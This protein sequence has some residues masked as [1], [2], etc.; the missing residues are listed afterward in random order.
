MPSASVK[1]K[2]SRRT[3]LLKLFSRAERPLRFADLLGAYARRFP[4]DAGGHEALSSALGALLHSGEVTRVGR[5]RGIVRYRLDGHSSRSSGTRRPDPAIVWDIVDQAYRATGGPV[6]TAAIRRELKARGAWPDRFPRLVAVLDTM[7]VDPDARIM[8]TGAARSAAALRRAPAA[9]SRARVPG[10]WVPAWAA[11]Q[12]AV[13]APSAA[14]ALRYAIGAASREAG[15]PVSQRELRWWIAAQPTDS[16]WRRELSPARTGAALRNVALRD[17]GRDDEPHALRVVEGPLTCH[18]GA[19]KRYTFGPTTDAE[20][21]ACHFMDAIIMLELDVELQTRIALPQLGLPAGVRRRLECARAAAVHTALATYCAS[22][23]T[24][25]FESA[26]RRRTRA[27]RAIASWQEAAIPAG[28]A[29]ITLRTEQRQERARWYAAR[30]IVH[31][32][33]K[34]ETT[35]RPSWGDAAYSGIVGHVALLSP[36]RAKQYVWRAKIAGEIAAPR[37]ELVY[38]AARR[39]PR[40]H[41]STHDAARSARLVSG[42]EL[43]LLDAV[44]VWCTISQRGATRGSA[45]TPTTISAWIA[46]I[47]GPVLRDVALIDALRRRAHISADARRRLAILA[48]LLRGRLPREPRG[49]ATPKAVGRCGS[50]R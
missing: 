45:P 47:V 39:F 24:R 43:A 44:D 3:R 33:G 50:W 7:A 2:E 48:E 49:S 21:R 16:W 19:P 40:P 25:A 23:D 1:K 32:M 27:M 26:R 28:P 12:C 42:D 22:L 36:A 17:R 20:I 29:L 30:E 14:N 9:P 8:S 6:A 35:A 4:D 13:T 15:M 5:G 31:H 41:D 34:H 10:F 18:G 37:P 11:P 46:T 38:S